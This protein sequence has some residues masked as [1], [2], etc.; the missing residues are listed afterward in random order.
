MQL[1]HK[2]WPRHCNTEELLV[3]GLSCVFLEVFL[4]ALYLRVS[5]CPTLRACTALMQV[6]YVPECRWEVLGNVKHLCEWGSSCEGEAVSC[7]VECVT[8]SFL[9]FFQIG[10]NTR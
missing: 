2:T 8:A 1:G 4:T 9:T 6:P 5:Y 3:I 7:H 10:D